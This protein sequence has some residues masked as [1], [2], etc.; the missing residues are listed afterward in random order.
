MT[1]IPG[2]VNIYFGQVI[3]VQNRLEVSLLLDL[4]RNLLTAKQRNIMEMYYDENFSLAEIADI[5]GSS[6]Q[7]IFDLIRRSEQQLSKYEEKL[8]IMEKMRSLEA[9]KTILMEKLETNNA[10]TKDIK[11]LI[12]SI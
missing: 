11:T 9:K 7:A 10:L 5:N 6:R 4:Y 3:K 2:S 8:R 1:A 12:E